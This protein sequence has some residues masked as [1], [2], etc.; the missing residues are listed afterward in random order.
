MVLGELWIDN[1]H[2]I[3]YFTPLGKE[4]DESWWLGIFERLKEYL[5][6]ETTRLLETEGYAFVDLTL[7]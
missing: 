6:D 1:R 3:V 7:L 4:R 5:G 2:S